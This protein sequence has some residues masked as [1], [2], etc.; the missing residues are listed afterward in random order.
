MLSEDAEKEAGDQS[1]PGDVGNWWWSC[2]VT[3][4]N[5]RPLPSDTSVN[6]FLLNI[7]KAVRVLVKMAQ[8]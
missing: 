1:A 5:P 3:R 8:G 6:F 7:L 4:L 2:E